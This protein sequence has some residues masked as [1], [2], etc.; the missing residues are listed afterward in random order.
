[1]YNPLN[2]ANLYRWQDEDGRRFADE[3]KWEQE[4]IAM[5]RFAEHEE[6]KDEESNDSARSGNG[7]HSVRAD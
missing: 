2:P 7:D 6:R 4:R 5:E 3:L 1:M